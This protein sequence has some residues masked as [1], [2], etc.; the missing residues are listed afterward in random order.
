MDTEVWRAE[1]L[2]IDGKLVDAAGGRTFDNVNP[3]TEEAIGVAADGSAADMDAAIG[4]ARR[5][6]DTTSWA[7][8]VDLR[9]RCLRQL[10]DALAADAERIRATIVAEVGSPV[11]LT[12]GAQLDSPLAGV[13]WVADLVERYEW[14]Q[15]LGNAEPFGVPSHR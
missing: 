2:L 9:V 1:R 5:A 7:T 3:A 13:S 12:H 11:V 8:D 6:F 4:A 10:S 15:D 14:E